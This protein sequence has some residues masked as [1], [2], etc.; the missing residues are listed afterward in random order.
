MGVEHHL[1]GLAQVGPHKRHPAVTEPHVRHLH[2][3]R[4]AVEDHDLVAPVELI[5]LAWRERERHKRRRS[6][7]RMLLAPA[8]CVP[9][10]CVV[11]ARIACFLL[12]LLEHPLRRQPLALGLAR[13][14]FK[15]LI[16][17]L[18]KKPKLRQR[19]RLA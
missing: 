19:L 3:D 16:E 10:N 2:L 9:A 4:H 1:L 5:G 15:Q 18:D 7:C 8:L 11:A 12:Q 6:C 17:R 14:L 13:I